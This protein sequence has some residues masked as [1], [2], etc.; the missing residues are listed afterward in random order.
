M[1]ERAGALSASRRPEERSD[2]GSRAIGEPG[3]LR[4]QATRPRVPVAAT[5]RETPS[6]R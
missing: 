4:G 6:S 5:V 3:F 2:D 1:R